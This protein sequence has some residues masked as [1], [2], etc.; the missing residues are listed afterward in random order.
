M[1][2]YRALVDVL[3]SH[4]CRKVLAGEEFDTVFPEVDGK[5]MNLAPNIEEVK[6]S[7]VEAKTTKGKGGKTKGDPSAN[8][9]DG[10]SLV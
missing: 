1:P 9:G 8:E 10:E 7:E 4:E 5:P 6:A 2:R 3:L